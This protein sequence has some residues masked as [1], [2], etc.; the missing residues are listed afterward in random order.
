MTA[1]TPSLF[2]F[3]GDYADELA[4]RDDLPT[5]L[6]EEEDLVVFTREFFIQFF[7]DAFGHQIV[8][9]DGTTAVDVFVAN[10]RHAPVGSP[11]G[12]IVDAFRQFCQNYTTIIGELYD[13]AGERSDFQREFVPSL[14]EYIGEWA[15]TEGNRDDVAVAAT[16][17][18]TVMKEAFTTLD[19]LK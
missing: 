7:L 5:D 9:F 4:A 6:D 16:N 14:L 2:D 15:T 17:A 11:A 10:T 13:P 8:T 19:D 3:I 18:L 12:N 1:L